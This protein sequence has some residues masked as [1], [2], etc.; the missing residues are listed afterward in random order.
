M[1]KMNKKRP[2]LKLAIQKIESL[3]SKNK[4]KPV[5]LSDIQNELSNRKTPRSKL[6]KNEVDNEVHERS[7]KKN[8]KEEQS[9]KSLE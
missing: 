8:N 2:F 3:F 4:D 7:L 6:L 5:V 9:S 1:Q